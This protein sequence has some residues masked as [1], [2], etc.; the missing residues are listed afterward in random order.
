MTINAHVPHVAGLDPR[1]LALSAGA[2]LALVQG[3][4]AQQDTTVARQGR[5]AAR[6][7]GHHAQASDSV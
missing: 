7:G 5:G 3:A 2:L 4:A 6:T 1:A